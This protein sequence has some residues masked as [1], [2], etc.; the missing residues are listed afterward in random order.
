MGQKIEIESKKEQ[1]TTTAGQEFRV[2]DSES[3]RKNTTLR[4]G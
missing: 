4:I 3:R 2:Q 1:Q